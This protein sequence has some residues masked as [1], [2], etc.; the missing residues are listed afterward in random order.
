MSRTIVN[1]YIC[2]HNDGEWYCTLYTNRT[3]EVLGGFKT[4]EQAVKKGF[5]KRDIWAK[6]LTDLKDIEN[7]E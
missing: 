1:F 7:G 3:L 6:V 4:E 2:Q 5:Q